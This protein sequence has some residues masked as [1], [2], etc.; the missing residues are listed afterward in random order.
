MSVSTPTLA[1]RRMTVADLPLL[2]GW[3]QRPHWREWWGDPDEELAHVRDMVEGRD[4]TE[5]YLIDMDG[6]PEGYIQMWHIADNRVEPWLTQAP[7][8]LDLPD[9]A[10]GIDLSLADPSRLSRGTGTAVLTRFVADLRKRGF[11]C[12]IIDPDPANLRA[13]RAYTK[14]GFRPVPALEGRTGDSL[15]MRHME[16]PTQ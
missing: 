12:I 14:A 7:W 8:L 5:P 4:S 6:T 11:G 15:V 1:F 9:D 16:E 10:V 13:V 2:H 3:M